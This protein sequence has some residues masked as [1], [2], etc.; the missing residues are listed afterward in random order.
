MGGLLNPVYGSPPWG[1]GGK[2]SYFLNLL[3]KQYLYLAF[4]VFYNMMNFGSY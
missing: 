4:N 3:F 2:N 1:I